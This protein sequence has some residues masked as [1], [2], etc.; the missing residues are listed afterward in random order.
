MTRKTAFLR[1]GLG[2]SSIIWDWHKVQTWNFTPV[3]KVLGADP[4]F[5]GSY[6][7]KT[8]RGAFLLPPLPPP[9][10]NRVKEG[11]LHK[12][13]YVK[14]AKLLRTQ[15]WRTTTNDCFCILDFLYLLQLY[16]FLKW[17]L[18]NVG[19]SYNK[20]FSKYEKWFLEWRFC[21]MYLLLANP[22]YQHVR[23][24]LLKDLLRLEFPSLR[25]L[26]GKKHPKIKLKR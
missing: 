6:R 19:S 4:Y 1:G 17:I 23:I 18:Y 14:F 25:I 10:L 20:G 9:I 11:L 21:V 24:N 13:F 16:H 15:F 22:F 3:W 8:G 2:S 12:S 5:C 26:P 7:G